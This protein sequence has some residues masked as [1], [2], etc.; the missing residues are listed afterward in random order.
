MDMSKLTIS[1]VLYKDYKDV[2]NLIKSI[3]YYTDKRLDKKI[4]IIDNSCLEDTNFQKQNFLGFLTGY[5]DIEYIDTKHNL[6]F[7]KGHNYVLNQLDSQYHAIVN[8]DIVLRS[9]VFNTMMS[10]MEKENVGMSIPKITDSEGKILEC[11]RRE[12]TL[13]DMFVRMFARKVFPKRVA[14][15][16]L[17]SQ[18]YDIPFDVPFGQGSF[19]LIKTKLW[20]KLHGFDERFFMYMEDADLCKRVHIEEKFMYCPYATVE[21]KWEKGS[22]KSF[23]LFKI[24]IASMILYFKKWGIKWW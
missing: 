21:H 7:G 3:E 13:W 23:K 2:E 16:T 14:Y 18:N 17:Q 24:H 9:E 1:I 4:F 22:H 10:F 5:K 8:P 12:I 11:Y 6:G 19:L 15:H 20:K